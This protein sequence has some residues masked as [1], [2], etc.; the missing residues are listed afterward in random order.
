MMRKLLPVLLAVIGL[1]V[2]GGVGLFL[3]PASPPADSAKASATP[4]AKPETAN[5]T[6]K[7][8][9][10]GDYEYAK[11]N[12]QFIVPIVDSGKVTAMVILSLSLQVTKG[13]SAEVYSME[14]KLRDAFLQVL[15][16]HA[17]SGGFNGNFTE[18]N[19]LQ[20]LR[21]ALKE[22]AIKVMGALVSDVLIVDIVRQDT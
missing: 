19:K 1:A 9:A 11:L 10:P 14:P 7:D 13:S 17:N 21:D 5:P 2:G 8:T 15:F 22:T 4:A 18:G 6:V 12:N 3:R 16:D 20:V